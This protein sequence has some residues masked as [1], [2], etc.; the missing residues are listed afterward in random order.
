VEHKR[1][2]ERTRWLAL[3]VAG[4]VIACLVWGISGALAASQ[5]PVPGASASG[6]LTLKMGWDRYPD[7][8]NPFTMYEA[9]AYEVIALN[10]DLLVGFDAKTLEHPQGLDQAT[11]LAYEWTQ[12][13]DQLSWTFK[14]RQ[15]V[16]WQDGQPFTAK[17]VV[18]TYEYCLKNSMG[19]Y[20][21]YLNFVK[22]VVAVDDYTVRFDLTQPK[23][24]ILGMWV[25]IIP[26]HIWSKIPGD[27]AQGNYSPK[28]P[29][30]GTG[31]FQTVAWK[32]QDFVKMA[33]NKDYWRGAPAV[34]E[35]LWVTYQNT[36]SM[37]EDLIAGKLQYAYDIP[38][39]DFSR[40][41]NTP[42][43]KAWAP[44]TIGFD[45]LAINSYNN[46]DSQG[47]PVLRD[48]KFRQALNWAVD[49]NAIAT[50]AYGGF[51]EPADTVINKGFF[52]N[53]DWHWTPPA[54]EAYGFDL[55]KAKALLDA[56]GYK[57]SNN[58]GIREDHQG[59]PIKLRLWGRTDSQSSDLAGRKIAGWF[60][61]IG[62]QIDYS[63]M[64]NQ[65]ITKFV[66]QTTNSQGRYAPDY[67]MFI[68]GWGGD[69]DPNFILSVFLTKAIGLNNWSD[70]CFSNKEF[71]KLFIKQQGQTDPAQRKLSIDRMQQILYEES[72]YIV[73]VYPKDSTGYQTAWGPWVSAPDGKGPVAYN[74]YPDS[75][76]SLHPLSGTA[77]GAAKSNTTVL[78]IV[79][80]AAALIVLG[81][82][83]V[84]V[85][86]RGKRREEVG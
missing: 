46:A 62:L 52:S 21:D 9:P 30:V 14:L 85:V 12:A 57:D 67:D 84:L 28:P 86:R 64:T 2:T 83:V 5:S 33:A 7:T 27:V 68:W 31:A 75:Y 73:L 70:S 51:G 29:L 60:K 54:N 49:K 42:G 11:G 58:D 4:I 17:D 53:P 23:A 80:V 26:E 10:Y 82:V 36:S 15:N 19:L 55:E 69:V 63:L 65:Q 72:P 20:I 3:A 76:I 43:L 38:P 16:K 8:F 61:Q 22:G 44:V 40:V 13:P 66:N 32:D 48:I 39:A 77:A 79:I 18:F 6:K 24:N 1:I 35:L 37:T 25:P 45:E 50:V 59:K 71:D 56:A 41:G 74:T 34:D 81:V 78:I 47:N